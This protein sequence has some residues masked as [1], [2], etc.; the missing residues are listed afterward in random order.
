VTTKQTQTIPEVEESQLLVERFEAAEVEL[1][2]IDQEVG[3][4]NAQLKAVRKLQTAKLA[5]LRGVARARSEEHPL[6][7]EEE[8][9]EDA[10]LSGDRDE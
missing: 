2:A 10:S 1:E 9:D 7:D 3:R 8:A 5:Q 4:L 6:L